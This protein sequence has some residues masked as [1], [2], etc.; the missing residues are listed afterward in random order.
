[1]T[2]HSGKLCSVD[3]CERPHEAKGLCKVHYDRLRVGKPFDKPIR[4]FMAP[5]GSIK[6]CIVDGCDNKPRAKGYCSK[7]YTRWWKFGDPSVINPPHPHGRTPCSVEGC[8]GDVRSAG[9]CSKHH[10]RWKKFGDPLKG[11][12]IRRAP[13]C[14]IEGCDRKHFGHGLCSMHRN[15]QIKYG[16]TGPVESTRGNGWIENGYRAIYSGD[17]KRTGEH[18]LVMAEQIGRPL[19]AWEHVH[20]LNGIRDD[21]RPENLEL[22]TKPHPV[23]QRPKDLAR[24]VIEF[25]PD[26]ICTVFESIEK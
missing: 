12:A 8:D 9:F 14:T 3:E 21:N 26:L 4:S 18:R 5:R 7:H 1:M 15:R 16:D 20:H 22:W 24:W 2:N 13:V 19:Y 11:A 23:G 6:V 25:Y 17:G 10:Y